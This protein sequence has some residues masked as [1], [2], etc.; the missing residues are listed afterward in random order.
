M[1]TVTNI[2]VTSS[3]M[4]EEH[5]Q[6]LAGVNEKLK[7][8]GFFVNV[9]KYATS[10]R[11]VEA[12]VWLGAFNHLD[13]SVLLDAICEAPWE[14]P[15]D[16]RMFIQRQ[17]DNSFSC[18]EISVPSGSALPRG[19]E[20]KEEEPLTRYEVASQKGTPLY[21]SDDQT[22]IF[23]PDGLHLVKGLG[24]SWSSVADEEDVRELR[25]KFLKMEF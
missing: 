11:V 14:D 12:Q 23:G 25:G 22:E 24:S 4:N 8:Y 21:M 3:I 5:H 10:Y 13:L 17:D 2:I 9:T 19:I 7:E 6:L 18:L 20:T 15:E 1:S 16:L